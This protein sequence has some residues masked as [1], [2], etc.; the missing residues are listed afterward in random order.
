VPERRTTAN[1][2]LRAEAKRREACSSKSSRAR[3]Y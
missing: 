3:L 2:G 1:R